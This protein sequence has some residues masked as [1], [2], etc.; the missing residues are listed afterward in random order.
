MRS[1]VVAEI[2]SF[3]VGTPAGTRSTYVDYVGSLQVEL[4]V[5]FS[6]TD[7]AAPL[8]DCRDLCT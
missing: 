3:G 1:A 7:A 6:W 8:A 5:A 4:T 2:H